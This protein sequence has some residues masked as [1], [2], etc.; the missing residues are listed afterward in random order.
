LIFGN[1]IIEDLGKG[2]CI[3]GSWNETCGIT[4]MPICAGDKVRMFLIVE[5]DSEWA[6][7]SVSHSYTT[8]LWRP[9][10][11]PIKGSYNEYGSIEDIEED[12]LT[13]LMLEHLKDIVVEV[14]NRMGEVFKREELDWNTAINF[15]ADEGLRVTDPYHVS[16]ITKQLNDLLSN[17]KAK[18]P[19]LPD[20][21][22]SSERSNL[23]KDQK[24]LVYN[25]PKVVRMYHMMV[26]EDV[27]QALVKEYNAPAVRFSSWTEGDMRAE[28]EKDAADYIASVR[29]D[30]EECANMSKTD[31]LMRNLNKMSRRWDSQNRFVSATN[32]LSGNYG[33]GSYL[34]KY[35]DFVEKKIKDGAA[36]ND[37]EIKNLT[38][39]FIDFVCFN[40]CMTLLRKMWAP[41]CGKG[42]QD[43]EFTL[44]KFL[45]ETIIKF[46]EK[47]MKEW[48]DM[49][50]EDP[51]EEEEDD[52]AE[53]GK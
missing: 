16:F 15:I 10:G 41:Q 40:Q 36:D 7:E 13:D 29:K 21:G 46:S 25:D 4:Q 22:Y 34:R 50:N 33:S 49:Y 1:L 28:L 51:L 38:V 35:L 43:R 6:R 8:D 24:E 20:N 26:L 52:N 19:D 39:Q 45:G 18:F 23:A 44:H 3:L 9:F 11:L 30:L 27:Y 31:I 2:R 48:D 32:H 37:I 5:T 12:S 53:E 42:G 17:V 14:P 47:K